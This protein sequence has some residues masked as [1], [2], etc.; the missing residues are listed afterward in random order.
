MSTAAVDGAAGGAAQAATEYTPACLEIRE[1]STLPNSPL[2]D[3]EAIS[4]QDFIGFFTDEPARR[5]SGEN[6]RP[7]NVLVRQDNYDWSFSDYAHL[8]IFHLSSRTRGC[9][10]G[11]SGSASTAS[12]RAGRVTT[13]AIWPPSSTS[14][15]GG[16]FKKKWVQYDDSLHLF[17]EHY[18]FNQPVPGGCNLSHVPEWVGYSC[19]APS[20]GRT[21]PRCCRRSR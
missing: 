10:C 13:T 11:T 16:W 18:C 14:P 21:R 9:R 17:R 15:A 5:F 7:L 6:H 20:R 1:R 2:Y 8:I 4:E 3:Q 19:W 12:W